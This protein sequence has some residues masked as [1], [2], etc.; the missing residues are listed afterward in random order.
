MINKVILVGRVG[1]EPEIRNVSK[2]N[3]FRSVVNFPLATHEVIT[4]KETGEKIELTE[5]HN[6]EMWDKNAENAAKILK[7]GRVVYLEGKIKNDSWIDK[8]DV[9]RYATKIR[10]NMFQVMSNLS[11]NKPRTANSDDVESEIDTD[12]S[13]NPAIGDFDEPI[14]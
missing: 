10:A 1:K 3:G 4:D 13:A 14:D 7:K 5:W 8:T 6:I 12:F 2:G 9:K 11:N